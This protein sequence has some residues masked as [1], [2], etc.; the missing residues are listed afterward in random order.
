METTAKALVFFRDQVLLGKRWNVNAGATV[1]TY[2]VGACLLAFPNVF[3]RWQGEQRRLA[4]AYALEKINCP[5][6]RGLGDHVGADPEDEVVTRLTLIQEVRRLP[7]RLRQVSAAVL[8]DDRT[9]AAAAESVGMT[10]RAVEGQFYRHRQSRNG[11][12]ADIAE[13]IRS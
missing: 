2:F 7:P 9:F 6:G 5:E 8:A 1:T 13:K 12:S 11:S 3:R 4:D 10:P